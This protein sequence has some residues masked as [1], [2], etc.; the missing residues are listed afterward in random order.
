VPASI[1]QGQ[2]LLDLIIYA[3]PPGIAPSPTPGSQHGDSNLYTQL[4]RLGRSVSYT[5]FQWAEKNF[6]PEGFIDQSPVMFAGL[7]PTNVAAPV[8]ILIVNI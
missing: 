7:Y 2:I 5:E 3:W 1:S 6:V 8:A 4:V